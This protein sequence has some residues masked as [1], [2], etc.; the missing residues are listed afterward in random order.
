M[1]GSNGSFILL[2][3]SKTFSTEL[4]TFSS[5]FG[6]DKNNLKFMEKKNK[7]N[8]I[9]S[10]FY[11]W[12]KSGRNKKTLVTILEN[13]D[14][15]IW[16]ERTS[17]S[18]WKVIKNGMELFRIFFFYLLVADCIQAKW[19]LPTKW[20]KNRKTNDSKHQKGFEQFSSWSTSQK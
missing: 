4:L 11:I 6:P 2:I 7:R 8:K 19:W 16:N 3:I 15:Q 17:F 10:S 13:Y 12:Q 5:K 1:R 14:S 18:T 9:Q 20:I